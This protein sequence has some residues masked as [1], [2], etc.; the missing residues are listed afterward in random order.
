MSRQPR[1]KARRNSQTAPQRRFGAKTAGS[2]RTG[3]M[4][5]PTEIEAMIALADTNR[6]NAKSGRAESRYY[7]CPMCQGWH[8]TSQDYR[9]RSGP[10]APGN[11]DR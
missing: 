3:K 4:R 7:R 1:R 9:P 2:C 6:G 8:M 11:H 10:T 5:F